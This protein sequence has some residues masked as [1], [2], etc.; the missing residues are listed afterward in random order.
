M[1]GPR[2]RT[3]LF[4]GAVLGGSLA[5]GSG[6]AA[7]PAGDETSGLPPGPGSDPERQAALDRSPAWSAFRGLH[8][9]WRA[10]WNERTATPHRALGPALALPGAPR[11]SAALDRGLRAFVAAHPGLFGPQPALRTLRLR[12]AGRVWYA[13]YRREVQGVPVLFEDWEFRV[14]EAGKLMAFGAD[15]HAFAADLRAAPPVDAGAARDAAS[16]ALGLPPGGAEGGET[17]WWLPD[18]RPGGLG[19]RLVRE[20]RART[21]EPPGSWVVLVDA[22]TGAVAWRHDRVRHDVSGTVTGL[23]HL[24]LPTDTPASRPFARQ[25]VDVG[26]TATTTDAQGAYS[27][28]ATGSVTVAAEI[29]G[30]FCD[31]NRADAADAAFGASVTAPAT[32]DVAWDDASSHA[33]ERDA[34]Y[35]VLLAHAHYKALDPGFTAN[36]Y[37]MPC[38]VNIAQTCNAFWDGTGINFFQAGNGCPNTATMPDVVYHEYGHGLNDNLYLQAGA[39]FGMLNGALHEGF[40]DVAAAFIQD[41]PEMGKGFFGPGTVLRD[42]DNANRWPDDDSGDP[43]LTGLI[44]G[45]AFW[46]LREA[47][48]LAAAESLSH[49][50]KYG[51]PDDNNNGTAMTE[52]FVE[53]LVADDDDGDLSNGTPRDDAI[54]SAFNAHGIGTQAFMAMSHHPLDDQFSAGPYPVRALI[55][56]QGPIGSLDPDSPRVHYSVNGGPYG[57]LAMSPLGFDEYEAAIPAPTGTIVRYYITAA[58]DFGAVSS[59]PAKAAF[60]PHLFLAGATTSNLIWDHESD[61]GWTAGLP[62]DDAVAGQWVWA[63]PVGSSLNGEPVQP[64]EDHTSYG[65]LCYVTQN[66][67]SWDLSPGAHDVDGGR[68]TL[69]T[70]L[71]DA[72]AAGPYPLLEYW[73]WYTNDLGANPGSDLWR[74]LLSNDG[75]ASWTAVESTTQSDNSWRRVVFFIHDYLPPTSQMLLRFIAEDADPPSLVEAAVDDMRLL[76][77][78]E[79]DVVGVAAPGRARLAL[80]PPAPNP[81]AARTSLRFT[82][83][84]AGKVRLT[85]HDL[86]GRR[87]RALACGAREPGAHVAVWDGRDEAG[88]AVPSG[89][90][91]VRLEALGEVRSQRIV[92]AR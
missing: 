28:P 14:S 18:P 40:A 66:P 39:A 67:P 48:G 84:R 89:L 25:H 10:L 4:C 34:Y 71:F 13:S 68:T 80:A 72:T 81:S 88:R 49:F 86:G 65:I 63:D 92:R 58:D 77:F 91:V 75:G 16:R 32:V 12:R 54:A 74:V 20:V 55:R 56:Y 79:G 57:G 19:H 9:D 3:L 53:A 76:A 2:L 61:A 85:I 33:A 60:K 17:L 21:S 70:M 73:R 7:A 44:L 47:I 36:D 23:V 69:T 78:D 41:T 46:D 1:R 83:P 30:P 82:L 6:W 35:H 45:G 8:G 24:V 15:A 43:H 42:L 62:D 11:D 87:V 37:A 64:E 90:Y 52:V 38:A 22:Q 31:V 27:A 50:A 5:A 51:L 26:G 59:H 29:R